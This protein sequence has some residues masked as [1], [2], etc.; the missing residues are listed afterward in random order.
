MAK[1]ELLNSQL[2]LSINNAIL[3]QKEKTFVF[4]SEKA[5]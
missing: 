4:A 3:D 5:D 2:L 1:I